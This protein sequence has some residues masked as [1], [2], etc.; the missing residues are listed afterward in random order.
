MKKKIISINKDLCTGCGNCVTSC[1]QGAIQ[2]INGKAKLVNENFCDGLGLCIGE[3]PSGALK[4][5]EKE[6]EEKKIEE[7]V[8]PL[9]C[10]C[11]GTMVMDRRDGCM[12]SRVSTSKPSSKDASSCTCRSELRQWPVQ[13]HLVPATAPYLKGSELVVLSSCSAVATPEVHSRLIKDRAVVMACP[14][15]DNRE[16]YLEKL[17]DIFSMANTPKVIVALMA[18]PCCSGLLSI[19]TEAARLSGRKDLVIEKMVV[20]L[21][22]NLGDLEEL[23]Y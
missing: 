4:I 19:V 6:I 3:C 8:K 10:G 11:P 20:S 2:I 5:I 23:T 17:R 9:A 1:H 12:S 22:G 13:L 18:V 14:K 15:L 21:D 16:G 7:K